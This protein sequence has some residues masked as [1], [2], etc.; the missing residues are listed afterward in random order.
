[1]HRVSRFFYSLADWLPTVRVLSR[2]EEPEGVTVV[3]L[4]E[5]RV[6]GAVLVEELGS[7]VPT[8]KISFSL[9]VA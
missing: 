7:D 2:Y 8:A 9:F 6:E 3:E 4:L 1:M 5:V